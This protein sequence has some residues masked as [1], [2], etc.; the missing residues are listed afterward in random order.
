MSRAIVLSGGEFADLLAEFGAV[1]DAGVA[2]LRHSLISGEYRPSPRRYAPPPP[3][4]QACS[5]A[6]RWAELV[7]GAEGAALRAVG[8]GMRG[9]HLVIVLDRNHAGNRHRGVD[10]YLALQT[11]LV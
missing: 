9:V 6:A 5:Y 10:P 3:I 11:G 4:W 8:A 7:G 1:E 2:L